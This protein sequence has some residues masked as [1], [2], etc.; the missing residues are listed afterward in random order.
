[1]IKKFIAIILISFILTILMT[2]CD[3]TETDICQEEDYTGV[4][5]IPGAHGMLYPVI[6]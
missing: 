2:A 6:Y 3:N 4:I 5:I 1:M